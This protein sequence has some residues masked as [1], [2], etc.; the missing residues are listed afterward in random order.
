MSSA[1]FVKF[2]ISQRG[3]YSMKVPS[4]IQW[5]ETGLAAGNRDQ[6]TALSQMI[7]YCVWEPTLMSSVLIKIC[8]TSSCQSL[9]IARG[10]EFRNL[11]IFILG[12]QAPG[13]RLKGRIQ[14][15]LNSLS[16]LSCAFN[17]THVFDTHKVSSTGEILVSMG[18]SLMCGFFFFF[19]FATPNC[20]LQESY[21]EHSPEKPQS[22]CVEFGSAVH[23]KLG[24][25][26]KGGDG[27][28]EETD[29]GLRRS[30]LTSTN[31]TTP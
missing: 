4:D 15:R 25:W 22:D 30:I 29:M 14:L 6:G 7:R 21:I 16:D 20:E 26:L 17:R 13:L 10:S 27:E 18:E 23:K 28:V 11:S 8:S 1:E 9:I 12:L 3:R 24:G 2:N 5:W 31:L 19:F